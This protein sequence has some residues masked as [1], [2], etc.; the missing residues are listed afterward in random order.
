MTVLN[1]IELV[2]IG[3]LAAWAWHLHR[4]L[5]QT[6]DVATR[7]YVELRKLQEA[8]KV[9]AA[10]HLDSSDDD[11]LLVAPP[12]IRGNHLRD[13]LQHYTKRSWPDAVREFY[14]RAASDPEIAP[15]FHGVALPA[16]QRHFTAAI[17]LLT[18]TGLTK[19]TLRH[20][21]H[22]HANVRTPDGT[23]ITAEVYNKTVGV[24]IDILTEWGVPRYALADLSRLIEPLREVIVTPATADQSSTP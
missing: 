1:L 23:P 11:E 9:S 22:R 20:L 15:Y 21:A 12:Q 17:V 7:T 3:A 16:L 10:Q 19:G 18:N 2:L 13:W 5:A 8:H 4:Q 24:L 14:G 6:R